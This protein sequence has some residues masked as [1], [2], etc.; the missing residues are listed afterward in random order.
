MVDSRAAR[1][2][3][4]LSVNNSWN[5]LNFRANVVRRLQTEGFAVGVISPQD[6][7]AGRLADLGVLHIP[8]PIDSKGLSPLADLALLRR[9]VGILRRH[10]PAALLA[11]TIKPNVYGSIAARLLGIPVINNVSGL[12]TAFIRRGLLTRV[13]SLLYRLAF[14]RSATVFFQNPDDRRMFVAEGLVAERRTAL[15]PGSGIDTE[16][17]APR[18]SAATTGE[19]L[20]FLMIARLLRDK[21]VVE[22]VDAARAIRT[23]H[24]DVRFQILGAVDAANRTAIG[25][26]VLAD[27]LAEGVVTHLGEAE[28]VRSAIAAADCVVLPSYREGMPR[29]L[30]EG[31]AMAKPLIATRVP[32][33]VEVA[34]EG[35]N[36]LLCEVRDARS[37]ADAMRRMIDLPAERRRAMGQAGR[38]IAVTEFGDAIVAD[39]YVAA[40]EA[41]LGTA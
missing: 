39:R 28:D 38:R 24:P 40:I 33:C 22:F 21:G 18:P 12:G 2:L 23:E 17:F 5:V 29:A 13:V 10:R 9:Y 26:D 6:A 37:L 31:A 4:L 25:R 15:L 8:V 19:G 7:H 11:W 30:L 20:T 16:R 41:A 3:I 27:W 32:G 14:A 34:R 1:G 36:A 35:E